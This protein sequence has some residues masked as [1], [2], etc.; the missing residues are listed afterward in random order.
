MTISIWSSH[1]TLWIDTILI[2]H[3]L[4]IK[5]SIRRVWY[6]SNRILGSRVCAQLWRSVFPVMAAPLDRCSSPPH[7]GC[8]H[9][10]AAPFPKDSFSLC[11]PP[12]MY[13]Y[14]SMSCRAD[15]RSSAGVSIV[16][17]QS[18]PSTLRCHNSGWS[19]S[20]MGIYTTGTGALE[21]LYTHDHLPGTLCSM[22]LCNYCAQDAVLAELL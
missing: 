18:Q 17:A 13:S 4:P 6:P 22:R 7:Q 14:M 1:C 2:L 11:V 19:Q 9:V 10:W 5:V 20:C 16:C 21:R 8:P 15:T 3:Y 12:C